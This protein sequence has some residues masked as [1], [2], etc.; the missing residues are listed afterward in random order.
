MNMQELQWIS[1]TYDG[2]A[3]LMG[4]CSEEG[5]VAMDPHEYLS[6]GLRTRVELP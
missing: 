6:Q 5:R 3:G 2:L 1:R 4:P